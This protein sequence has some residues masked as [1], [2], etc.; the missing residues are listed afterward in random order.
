M[1][2]FWNFPKSPCSEIQTH[3]SLA[4]C[5]AT[6][7]KAGRCTSLLGYWS[8]GWQSWLFSKDL[9]FPCN[10]N[11]SISEAR[12]GRAMGE[13]CHCLNLPFAAKC[14]WLKLGSSHPLKEKKKFRNMVYVV[15]KR[16]NDTIIHV[17]N[18]LLWLLE[19]VKIR[20]HQ[21]LSNTLKHHFSKVKLFY[22][23]W[24]NTHLL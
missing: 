24:S 21:A 22:L 1:K 9:C 17:G 16:R 20:M 18:W 23:F 14:W 7:P 19:C 13:D 12:A 6:H 5:R 4:E 10:S 3:V 11:T 2:C 15:Y 8:K